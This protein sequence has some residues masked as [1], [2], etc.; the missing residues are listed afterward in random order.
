MDRIENIFCCI[1]RGS[2]SEEE[3]SDIALL[4]LDEWSA[5]YEIALQNN[6]TPLLYSN[7]KSCKINLPPDFEETIRFDYLNFSQ[8]DMKRKQ[9]LRE[10][11]KF[12]NE[13]SIEH[14]LLK[15]SH[16]A[17]KIYANS[18]LRPMCDIDILIRKRD[19]DAAFDALSRHGYSSS[20]P[21]NHD[22]ELIAPDKHYPGLVKDGCMFVELH[23]DVNRQYDYKN[24]EKIWARAET[25]LLDDLKTKVLCIEDL[26]MHICVHKGCDDKFLSSLL[27]LNDIRDILANT[28]T[29]WEKLCKL[30]SSRDEWNNTKCLFSALYLSKKLLG[31]RVPE[32]FMQSIS[33]A[34]FDSAREE[35]LIRQ[36]FS[37]PD[38][39][40][41]SMTRTVNSINK[42]RA[43]GNPLMA[44]KHLLSPKRLCAVYNKKYSLPILPYLYCKRIAGKSSE[45]FKMLIGLCNQSEIKKLY[46]V[47]NASEKVERWLKS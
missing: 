30:A 33:P 20:N 18:V 44:F 45:T 22:T 17:E 7:L 42:I 41:P 8:C 39:L 46:A 35:L 29:D 34:D 13:N 4:S 12:F 1:L 25:V 27:L 28:K 47:A 5:I 32:S 21:D 11:I 15:G 31:V 6:L 37:C 19:F 16:L 24:I 2:L 36:F 14:V 9:Q 23:W 38:S 10:L 26:L 3:L 43:R 40:D